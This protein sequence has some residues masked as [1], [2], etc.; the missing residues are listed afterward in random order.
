[1][2]DYVSSYPKELLILYGK[3]EETEW[4]GMAITPAFL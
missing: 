2:H 3:H 4:V 1:M